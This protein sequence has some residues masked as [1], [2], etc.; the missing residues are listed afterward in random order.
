MKYNH[1]KRTSKNVEGDFYTTGY[2]PEGTESGDCLDCLLPEIEAPEL[3]A[4]IEKLDTYTHFVKQPSNA[5]ELEQACGACEVCCVSAL[6]YGGKDISIIKKLGN[7][8]DYCDYIYHDGEL[9]QSLDSAGEVLPFAESYIE[10]YYRKFKIDKREK[11]AVAAIR[12]AFGAEDDETGVT[13]FIE[14]HLEEIETQYWEKH[15]GTKKPEQASVLGILV[16]RS[17]WGDEDD[18]GIDTFDFTLPEEVTGYVI[19][20]RFDEAGNIEG[21]SMES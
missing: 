7:N 16:L 17:H 3:L 13:L 12:N 10:A 9:V 14:H 21:I 19:S 1:P 5:N 4:D 15:L 2:W 18:D 8:P 20:V 6:R 11:S